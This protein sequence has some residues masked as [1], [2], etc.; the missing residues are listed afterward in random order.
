MYAVGGGV[1]QRTD[2][3]TCERTD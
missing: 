2:G 1:I 3:Q